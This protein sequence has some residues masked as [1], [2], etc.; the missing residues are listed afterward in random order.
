VVNPVERLA[1][2]CPELLPV[3]VRF[4]P[5]MAVGMRASKV[6]GIGKFGPVAAD[7]VPTLLHLLAEDGMWISRE[8]ICEALGAIGPKARAALPKLRELVAHERLWVA[9]ASRAA[10]RKIEADK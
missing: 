8:A 4:L 9:L 5:E 3:A 1:P 6:V 7:A 10:I 2:D